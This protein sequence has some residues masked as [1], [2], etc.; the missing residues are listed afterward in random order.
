MQL[1]EER[2]VWT[3][4]AILNQFLPYEVREI[5]NS[6]FILPLVS[7]VFEDGPW[8]DTQVR[9]G[10][11]PRQDV[12]AR[13]YQR[14]Y[15][16]NTSHQIERPSLTGSRDDP[17]Q[18]RANSG[19][20]DDK[21]SHIFDGKTVRK[22]T[23]GF[24]LCDI[25]DEMLKEMIEAEDDLR[26]AC[27]ERDGWYSAHSF[28]RIKTVLRHKFFA[29]LGGHI[30]TR[31]ECEALLVTQEGSSKL[32]LPATQRIRFGRH[33]MAKGAMPAEDMAA[34]RLMVTLGQK[35]KSIPSAP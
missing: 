22:E 5:I 32:Q 13:F 4:T 29:L 33:N 14:L 17:P 27:H 10:Y 12:Q 24:Q 15:F 19:R 1:F 8:R 25:Q 20:D 11:D 2:P 23:A 28:E 6:K 30:A 35:S 21:M 3:R 18:T 7:Y 31:E 16:R 34:H 9:L 26:E